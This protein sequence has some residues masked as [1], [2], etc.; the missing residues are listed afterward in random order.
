MDSL[1]IQAWTSEFRLCQ[2]GKSIS[3]NESAC[4][5]SSA[6]GFT[7]GVGMAVA[8]GGSNL[9]AARLE[10]L[11]GLGLGVGLVWAVAV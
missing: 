4:S 6:C 5:N 8:V 7:V 11:V 3:T 9:G 10:E 1:W 2:A